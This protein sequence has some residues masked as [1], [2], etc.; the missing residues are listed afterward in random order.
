MEKKKVLLVGDHPFL[1]TGNGNMMSTMLDQINW[2]QFDVSCFLIGDLD[3]RSFSMYDKLEVPWIPAASMGA[4]DRY[5]YKKLISVLKR[6]KIDILL[7]VG[8]DIFTYSPAFDAIK[9]VQERNPFQWTVIAPYDA[10]FARGDHIQWFHYPDHVLVY[11]KYGFDKLSKYVDNVKYFRPKL[12]YS[13]NYTPLSK[14]DKQ[15]IQDTMFG[16]DTS[17]KVIFGFI[18]PNQ[19][20]KNIPRMM[21]GINDFLASGRTDVLFYLHMDIGQGRYN[22]PQLISDYKNLEGLTFYNSGDFK[23]SPMEMSRLYNCLD[24]YMLFSHQEGLSWTPLEAMLTGVPC[25]LSDTTAHKDFIPNAIFVE[26]NET[27]HLLQQ[28]EFGTGHV[29]TRACSSNSIFHA[30]RK[31]YDMKKNSEEG[32]EEYDTLVRNGKKFADE[33]VKGCDNIND[34]LNE[35]KDTKNTKLELI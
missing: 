28:T 33:W 16:M 12:A 17:D 29:E 9:K 30:L 31:A 7:F 6:N 3:P 11:S 5:G 25:L 4:G 21:K 35:I 18:G 15:S 26:Q 20:R 14:E 10:T 13:E 23:V 8:I 2:N 27:D 34:F 32:S 19:K 1:F 24:F 22:I